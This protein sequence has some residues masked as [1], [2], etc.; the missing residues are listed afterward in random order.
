[1]FKQRHNWHTISKWTC[2]IC[3]CIVSVS[4]CCVIT[5]SIM[6]ACRMP[7]TM[8]KLDSGHHCERTASHCAFVLI[9]DFRLSSQRTSFVIIIV[10]TMR[11]S[12]IVIPTKES[13]GTLSSR[14]LTGEVGCVGYCWTTSLFS[15]WDRYR[16]RYEYQ[17]QLI[18]YL[19]SHNNWPGGCWE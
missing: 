5:D 8:D 9:K 3:I 13:E 6:H 17:L 11:C 14:E 2:I 19:R 4:A 12:D 16:P 18:K 7:H 15:G 1:M 10:L